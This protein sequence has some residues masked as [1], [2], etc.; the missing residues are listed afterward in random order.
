M[1][2]REWL[3]DIKEVKSTGLGSLRRVE[4]ELRESCYR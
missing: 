1:E 2:R 4:R 3:K